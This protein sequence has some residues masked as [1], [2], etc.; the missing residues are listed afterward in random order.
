METYRTFEELAQHS[1]KV[2]LAIGVFDGLHLGHA[3][4][5]EHLVAEADR[6]GARPVVVTFDHHPDEIITGTYQVIR[7]IRNEA[8][9]KVDNKTPTTQQ[10]T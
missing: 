8:Q 6:R 7:P 10:K 9:V 3:Y 2:C 1:Q 4:L 5:L